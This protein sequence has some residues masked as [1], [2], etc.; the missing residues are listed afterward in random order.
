MDSTQPDFSRF[1]SV[2]P[3]WQVEKEN[4]R[5]LYDDETGVPLAVVYQLSAN[6]TKGLDCVPGIGLIG[7]QFSLDPN[8]PR[9]LCCGTLNSSKVV[10]LY[11]MD[12]VLSCQFFPGEFTRIFGVP[13]SELADIEVPLDNLLHVGSAV[14]Q[15]ALATNFEDR[16]GGAQAFIREWQ[17][18]TKNTSVD[19]LTQKMMLDILLSHGDRRL[20]ELEEQTGYSARYLQKIMLEHIGLAPKTALSN[21]RFQNALRVMLDQPRLSVAEVAQRCGYYD[22]SHFTKVFKE[23][24]G[25]TPSAF[26]DSLRKKMQSPVTSASLLK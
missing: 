15:I 11:G 10:P 6:G 5:L 12:K 17:T 25:T 1:L 16:V 22:Q 19:T 4:Q 3:F 23:Y 18:R 14:E 21:I 26:Q 9:A 8:D 20:S 24:V 2:Q 13:S 7:I